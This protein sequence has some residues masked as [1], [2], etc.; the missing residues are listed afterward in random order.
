M[1]GAALRPWVAL[2]SAI[3]E[4]G[5]LEFIQRKL[6]PNENWFSQLVLYRCPHVPCVDVTSFP[7]NSEAYLLITFQV[8]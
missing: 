2:T 4:L 7:Q 6:Y 8:R 5:R 3:A 1:G